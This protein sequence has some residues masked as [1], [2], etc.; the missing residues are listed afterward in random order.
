[1][2][3]P[4]NHPDRIK[5]ELDVD[6]E[7]DRAIAVSDGLLVHLLGL[8]PG[9]RLPTNLLARFDPVEVDLSNGVVTY[10]DMKMV[11]G[12]TG[13]VDLNTNAVNL[14]M[15][16]PAESLATSVQQLATATGT[17]IDVALTGAIR[18]RAAR[19]AARMW[20]CS[21]SGEGVLGF[22]SSGVP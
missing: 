2:P 15:S 6:L 3:S 8:I 13:L 1:M 14:V 11:L 19:S 5:N 17:T 16:M 20:R 4:A 12:F 21:L 18:R 22:W 7:L 10:R 9:F